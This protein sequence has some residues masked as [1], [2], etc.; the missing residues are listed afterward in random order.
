MVGLDQPK[1]TDAVGLHGFSLE[2]TSTERRIM[3]YILRLELENSLMKAG[4]KL[5]EDYA[6]SSKFGYPD[7]H[8]NVEDL[9]LRLREISTSVE[10]AEDAARFC[11]NYDC[12]SHQK[13]VAWHVCGKCDTE[14]ELWLDMVRDHETAGELAEY[15]A[16]C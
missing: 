14:T 6:N 8:M 16:G 13:Q 15:N 9:R 11:P 10:D 4:F 1:L 5:L 12:E 3:N 7:N 2:L